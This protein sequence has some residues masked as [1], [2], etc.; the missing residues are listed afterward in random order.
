MVECRLNFFQVSW[1]VEYRLNICQVLN[2]IASIFFLWNSTTK[3][4]KNSSSVL[5]GIVTKYSHDALWL[6]GVTPIHRNRLRLKKN[7]L[8]EKCA[9]KKRV[10][11]N[12]DNDN[13][14]AIKVEFQD[15][16]E[17]AI[18]L[19]SCMRSFIELD[20]L[21]TVWMVSIPRYLSFKW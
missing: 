12:Y 10:F 18:L 2:A 9:L 16:D 17:W 20:W 11:Q 6:H 15:E 19:A 21:K 8:N 13:K 5:N 4:K 14:C 3:W 7:T 1:S